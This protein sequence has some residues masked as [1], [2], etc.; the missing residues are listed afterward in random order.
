[1]H[2]IGHFLGI[3]FFKP[4]SH[5]T[6]RS[7]PGKLDFVP[8]SG[9]PSSRL[10]CVQTIDTGQPGAQALNQVS[11]PEQSAN[12]SRDLW[13]AEK[14]MRLRGLTAQNLRA[15]PRGI[16]NE[17]TYWRPVETHALPHV[18]PQ[19]PKSLPG[20]KVVDVFASLDYAYSR[21]SDLRAG[22]VRRV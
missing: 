16:S 1:M 2:E 5:Q 15:S 21:K 17:N 14:L 20:H 19:K 9:I 11:P 3:G 7:E 6:Y 18:T 22:F 10:A 8:N 4:Y 13:R 12:S